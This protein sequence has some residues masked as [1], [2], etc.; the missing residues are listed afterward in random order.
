MSIPRIFHLTSPTTALSWEERR[1]VAR[2]QRTLSGWTCKHWDDTANS[3]LMH[4]AFPHLAAR[5]DAIRFG[6]MKADIARYAYMHVDG[7]FYFDTDYKLLA[8]LG[9]ALLEQPCVLPIE[10]GA[11]GQPNFKL[12]NAVFGSE[13]G[14]PFWASLIEH[15][16]VA[17]LPER[18][19]D[20][21]QIPMVSGP[22]GLTNFY[23]SRD[24]RFQGIHCPAR[25]A[26]HPDRT[27]F[28]LGHRGGQI[29][30][31]SH[32]CWASWRGKSTRRAITNYLRRKLSALPI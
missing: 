12:G 4:R 22:R 13:A 29:A 19:T 26:F 5:F 21:R 14:H 24:G 31:G 15:I 30:V 2:L 10:E 28:G 11:L 6:V 23:L 3:A 18:L 9:P 27:W 7:G 1:I 32:L 17:H 8:A 25:D 16:F 20:H